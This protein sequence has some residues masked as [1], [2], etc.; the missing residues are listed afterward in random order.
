[1]RAA[2]IFFI[3]LSQTRTFADAKKSSISRSQSKVCN[4]L[5]LPNTNAVFALASVE[6]TRLNATQRKQQARL[7]RTPGNPKDHR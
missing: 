4:C 2:L 6:E 3:E 5:I 1:M 7:R